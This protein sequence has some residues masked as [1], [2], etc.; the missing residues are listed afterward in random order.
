[1]DES[2][3]RDKVHKELKM[4][5][6]NYVVNEGDNLLYKILIDA[7]GKLQPSDIDSPKR[8][9]YAFQTDILIKNDRVPLVVIETKFGGFSTHDILTYSTKAM[10]HKEVYPY[11]RYGL[12]VGGRDKIDRKFFIHN[13]GFDFAVAMGTT[14]DDLR[15]LV[16]IV[17]KQIHAAELMLDILKKEKE[18]RKYVADIELVWV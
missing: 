13:S 11:I 17:R 14:Q 5:L 3:F 16:E 1:M 4:N 18:V 10:K 2:Q 15:E 9:Q 6:P 12:V 7:Q 8:G